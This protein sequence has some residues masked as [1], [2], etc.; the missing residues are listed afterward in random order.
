MAERCVL[1]PMVRINSYAHVQESILFNGAIIG[2]HC[3]I[4]RAIVEKNVE[5]PEHTVIGHNL[6]E[7]AKRFRVTPNGVVVVESSEKFT[8]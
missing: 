1:S 5:I 4:K 8:K 2:R 7:D 6:E 3:H